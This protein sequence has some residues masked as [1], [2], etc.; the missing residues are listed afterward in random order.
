MLI[1]EFGEGHS[2][3]MGRVEGPELERGGR[4]GLYLWIQVDLIC[5]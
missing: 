1:T 2:F 5:I 4:G 3:F